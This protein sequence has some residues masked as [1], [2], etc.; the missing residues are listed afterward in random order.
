M[1]CALALVLGA[2]GL[3]TGASAKAPRTA[4][5]RP[6]LI[7]DFAALAQHRPRHCLAADPPGAAPAGWK[8]EFNQC[9]WQDRLRMRRWSGLDTVSAT[10]C[11]S[12]QARWWAW[13]RGSSPIGAGQPLAWRA[14]WNEHSLDDE[15]GAEKRI[16]VLQRA[17]SGQW[18]AIE[19]RWTPSTRAATRRWQEGRWKLLAALADGLRQPAATVAGAPE[20]RM[21]QSVWEHHVGTRAGEI[22]GASWRWQRDGLCLRTDPV[23]LGQQQLHIPYSLDDGRLEQRAAMR[24]QLARRYPKAE[25]LTPFGLIAAAGQARGGAKFGAVWI[26]NAEIKGQLWIPTKGD[27]P[28]V[29]L[30]INA[31]VAAPA[32]RAPDQADVARAAQTVERELAALA[33]RWSA[34][35]E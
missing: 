21:L 17:R 34:E 25:W 18:N 26:D 28:L 22:S 20:N 19:W 29:R 1:L 12:Q 31:T 11:V 9:A 4:P 7:A 16:V 30:R 33:Q 24:L 10:S 3:S 35:H 15:S 5:A 23:G 2:T 13:A 27:G 6:D 32:G 14:N 8:L